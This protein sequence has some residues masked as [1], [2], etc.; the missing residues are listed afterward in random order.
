MN[1]N[2]KIETIISDI[3]QLK[4]DISDIKVILNTL[5]KLTINHTNDFVCCILNSEELKYT[6]SL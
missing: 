4:K 2:D 3:E 1:K 5:S 6:N